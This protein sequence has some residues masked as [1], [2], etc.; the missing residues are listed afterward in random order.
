MGVGKQLIKIPALGHLRYDRFK[1]N[2]KGDNLIQSMLK[3]LPDNN[4]GI[5]YQ[6]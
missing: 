1:H 6:V 5:I 2:L 3:S 4:D